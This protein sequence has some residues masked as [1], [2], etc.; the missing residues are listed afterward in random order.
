M[1]QEA[2]FGAV[3]EADLE[4]FGVS[5]LAIGV[6]SG[7]DSTERAYGVSP[8]TAFRVAS[9]TKPIVAAC[10][11]R[12]VEEGRL[13]LDEPLTDLRLPWDGITLRHLLSHQA[14]LAHDWPTPLSE[15]GEGEDALQRLAADEAVGGPV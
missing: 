14:G 10:A 3:E 7:G 13:S 9:I 12:L 5:A 11:M 8:E 6:H 1:E 4:R 2:I 15:Y